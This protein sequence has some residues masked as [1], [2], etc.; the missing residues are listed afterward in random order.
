MSSTL[1]ALKTALTTKDAMDKMRQKWQKEGEEAVRKA[2]K[3]I[4]D[5]KRKAQQALYR[6][7]VEARKEE[8]NRKKLLQE[9]YKSGDVPDPLLLVPIRDPEKNP[10]QAELDTLQPHPCLLQALQE[11]QT[12]LQTPLSQAIMHTALTYRSTPRFCQKMIP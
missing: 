1:L 6:A 11:A 8:R 2:T 5:S 12:V 9:F 7:G 10:T 4:E 3:A